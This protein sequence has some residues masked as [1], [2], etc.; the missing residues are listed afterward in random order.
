MGFTADEI[1]ALTD[2]QRGAVVVALVVAARADGRLD[3]REATLITEAITTG[4]WAEA[5]VPR[6]AAAGYLQAAEARFGALR[7]RA[8]LLALGR[9]CGEAIA[10]PALR[11]KV[12]WAMLTVAYADGVFRA[13]E[14]GF[15]AAFSAG[16]GL[17]APRFDALCDAAADRNIFAA[18]ARGK[19]DAVRALLDRGTPVN[20]RDG[21]QWTPLHV[22]ASMGRLPIVDLLLE[23]GADVHAIHGQGSPPLLTACNKPFEAVVARLLRAGARPNDAHGGGLTALHVASMF[24]QTGVARAL[25]AGG[26]RLDLADA[27]G[28]TP[29]HCAA[30]EGRAETVVFLL[31][32][33]APVDAR[34]GPGCTALHFAATRGDVMSLHALLDAGADVNAR[35]HDGQTALHYAALNR[36]EALALLLAHGARPDAATAKCVTP[37]HLAARAGFTACARALL[38]AG[39]PVDAANVEG[40][41]ALFGAAIHDRKDVY[42]LLLARGANPNAPTAQGAT[43]AGSIGAAKALALRST[44]L[45]ASAPAAPAAPVTPAAPTASPG[46]PDSPAAALERALAAEPLSGDAAALA[47]R[48]DDYQT[49]AW[50]G[51]QPGMQQVLTAGTDARGRPEYVA[52]QRGLK[53]D[54]RTRTLIVTD[55]RGRRWV[56]IFTT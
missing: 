28:R 49:A 26:A 51:D 1:R 21:N 6:E 50:T 32:A 16:F 48:F 43:P 25:R 52:P 17:P 45:A 30:S 2:A 7:D 5:G 12:A 41:T 9:A 46:A 14:H 3:P 40:G 11:E 13:E 37:L 19:V 15:L 22:A 34:T 54:A 31:L 39:A 53:A 47:A 23:R 35:D 10:S 56:P 36:P 42:E 44:P 29:L 24:G 20:A 55:A 33:G 4:P 27:G 18:T 8:G 38:D